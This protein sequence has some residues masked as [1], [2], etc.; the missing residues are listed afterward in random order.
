MN[1]D[2]YLMLKMLMMV[3]VVVTIVKGIMQVILMRMLVSGVKLD[4]LWPN[5]GL[6]HSK[7]CGIAEFSLHFCD[8]FLVRVHLC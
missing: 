3:A 8:L 7:T 4:S 1:N 2:E 5:C 6:N